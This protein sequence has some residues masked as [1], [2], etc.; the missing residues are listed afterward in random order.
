MMK[1][2]S[3]LQTPLHSIHKY[4]TMHQQEQRFIDAGWGGF[5]V[6]VV[7]TVDSMS[8]SGTEGDSPL[9]S[10]PGSA[11]PGAAGAVA[12]PASPGA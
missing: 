11:A 8:A 4:P 10:A 5:C 9:V 3:K 6:R 7:T 12:S 2:F 1:H